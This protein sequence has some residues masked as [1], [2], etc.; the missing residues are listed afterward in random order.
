MRWYFLLA[1]CVIV[2]LIAARQVPVSG[3][4]VPLVV[5][6]SDHGSGGPLAGI[7]TITTISAAARRITTVTHRANAEG[8]ASIVVP[9][10]SV[11]IVAWSNGYSPVQLEAD[12][13]SAITKTVPLQPS[14]GIA[15]TLVDENGGPVFGSVRLKPTGRSGSPFVLSTH[16]DAA[17]QFLIRNVA[18]NTRYEASVNPDSCPAVDGGQISLTPRERRSD[19]VLRTVAC[20]P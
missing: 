2:G 20:S 13:S 7:V 14:G 18:T 6:L 10:G 17:G 19:V 5:R 3:A 8:V 16:T 11:R 9:A 4:P 12:V 15:G 1:M